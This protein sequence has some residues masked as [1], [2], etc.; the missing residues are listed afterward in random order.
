ML[1]FLLSALNQ[2]NNGYISI[3]ELYNPFEGIA[4]SFFIHMRAISLTIDNLK[5]E[6]FLLSARSQLNNGCKQIAFL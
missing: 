6:T 5:I 2:F 1:F 3:I 4:V